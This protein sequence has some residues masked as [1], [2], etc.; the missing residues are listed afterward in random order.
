MMKYLST[1]MV[2]R[3]QMASTLKNTKRNAVNW[4]M[5][6]PRIQSPA[7]RVTKEKGMHVS[8]TMMSANAR[9]ANSKLIA[10]RIAGF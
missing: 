1:D 9:L 10:E 8:A 6:A 3:I 7:T 4:H 2:A 5:K